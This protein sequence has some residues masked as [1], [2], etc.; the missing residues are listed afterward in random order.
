MEEFP[1][2]NKFRLIRFRIL[3]VAIKRKILK[4]MILLGVVFIFI[5]VIILSQIDIHNINH[6]LRW[7]LRV[8]TSQLMATSPF[9]SLLTLVLRS[10]YSFSLNI[11]A[12]F[13]KRI[14][15]SVNLPVKDRQPNVTIKM[16]WSLYSLI[17]AKLK[18]SSGWE[19]VFP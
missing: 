12:A 15:V 17:E 10:D 16:G 3:E 4:L 7:A 5:F 2:E 1:K 11:F 19:P 18:L 13:L 9:S 8:F 14:S 6:K